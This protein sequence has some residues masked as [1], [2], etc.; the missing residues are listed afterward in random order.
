MIINTPELF[1]LSAQDIGFIITFYSFLAIPIA[2]AGQQIA[3]WLTEK[4]LMT[5][6]HVLLLFLMLIL[7]YRNDF[8]EL[9]GCC[10]AIVCSTLL[11]EIGALSILQK[12][13]SDPLQDYTKAFVCCNITIKI[14]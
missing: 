11:L 7:I 3:N 5:V 1:S 13:L 4:M 6:S 10:F 2:L 9:F 8:L 12:A 14:N